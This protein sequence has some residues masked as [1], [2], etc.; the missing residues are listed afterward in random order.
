MG[1]DPRNRTNDEITRNH[2]PGDAC[3]V[4]GAP[5]AQTPFPST[6]VVDN[7]RLLVETFRPSKRN[8]HGGRAAVAQVSAKNVANSLFPAAFASTMAS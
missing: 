1:P 3:T 2:G 8:A 5:R 7:R 4:Y 6:K